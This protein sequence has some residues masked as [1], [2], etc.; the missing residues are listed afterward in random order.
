M[1]AAKPV[2]V[3][4]GP[5]EGAQAYDNAPVPPEAVTVA[6]PVDPPKQFTLVCAVI[7]AETAVAGSVMVAVAVVV[8]PFA[9]VTV[10]V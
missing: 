6:E 9:S 3:A 4:A 1:P 10:T 2:A 7:E 5:P 8:Q